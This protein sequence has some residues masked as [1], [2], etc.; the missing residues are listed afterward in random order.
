HLGDFTSLGSFSSYWH[1]FDEKA[2]LLCHA[3]IPIYPAFGNHEYVPFGSSGRKN[4]VRRFPFMQ[5]SWYVEHVDAIAV[6]ILNSNFSH[7]RGLETEAQQRW[8]EMSLNTL[9][10]DSSVALIVV[11]CHHPPYTNSKV[12]GPS[13]EVQRFFVPPF[14]RSQKAKVF[15]SGHAHAFEHFRVSGKHFLVIGG[16][17]GLLHPLLQGNEQRQ[18][19][20]YPHES[21]R[22][23]FHYLR[24]ASGPDSL[25]M[26]VVRLSADQTSF[27]TSYTIKV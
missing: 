12:I 24:C 23:F 26:S 17:G 16:G 7:L 19:D 21:D 6:V 11:A 27:Y 20:Y 18:Q 5:T 2:S 1:D 8:Y 14:T 13:S 9:D 10:L 4:L 15:V 3:G 25:A 22:S